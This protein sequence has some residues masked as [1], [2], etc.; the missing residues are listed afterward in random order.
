MQ[1]YRNA[2]QRHVSQIH[3]L[4]RVRN[5]EGVISRPE[6]NRRRTE[7]IPTAAETLN[8]ERAIGSRQRS[9]HYTGVR[10]FPDGNRRP[11]HRG[12]V[13]SVDHRTENF[14]RV[15]GHNG[16]LRSGGSSARYKHEHGGK[17]SRAPHRRV[18]SAVATGGRFTGVSGPSERAGPMRRAS[19]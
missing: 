13:S 2:R 17:N 16:I 18:P 5:I 11:R 6:T 7:V 4:R 15:R 14:S 8:V 1:S 9:R 3:S 12:L 10:F 19:M